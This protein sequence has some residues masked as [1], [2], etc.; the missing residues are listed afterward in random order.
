MIDKSRKYITRTP[1][2]KGHHYVAMSSNTVNSDLTALEKGLL[3]ILLNNSDY[4]R[5][6]LEKLYVAAH[7][8]RKVT[9][10]GITQLRKKGYVNIH[11]GKGTNDSYFSAIF[12]D[13]DQNVVWKLNNKIG[14]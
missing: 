5:M 6:S 14:L 4:Y 10:Y 13:N 1:K 11:V 12:E 7:M 2:G 3:L 8:D 9:Q